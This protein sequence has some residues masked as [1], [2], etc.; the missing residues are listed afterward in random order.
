MNALLMLQNYIYFS[1]KTGIKVN[2]TTL[3]SFPTKGRNKI[4]N[5]SFTSIVKRLLDEQLHK[6]EMLKVN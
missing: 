2:G 5:L 1:S 6:R 4:R 3:D